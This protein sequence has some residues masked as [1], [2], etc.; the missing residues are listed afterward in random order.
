M[1]GIL[2]EIKPYQVGVLGDSL[3][4]GD[5]PIPT[6][7]VLLEI[8]SEEAL[9]LCELLGEIHGAII[10]DGVIRE[11]QVFD[12]EG[13]KSYRVRYLSQA[14]VRNVVTGYHQTPK[15]SVLSDTARYVVGSILSQVAVVH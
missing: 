8:E 3:S 12:K 10:S 2:L 1:H 6:D 9:V 4:E 13:T 5:T 15:S 7:L 14:C 11:V